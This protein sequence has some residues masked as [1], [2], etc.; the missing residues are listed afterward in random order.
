MATAGTAYQSLDESYLQGNVDELD[1]PE[2]SE[3]ILYDSQ[4]PISF[5]S[6]Y[7]TDDEIELECSQKV[8]ETTPAISEAQAKKLSTFARKRPSTSA[9]GG[10]TKKKAKPKLKAL[11]GKSR[12]VKLGVHFHHSDGE[13]VTPQTPQPDVQPPPFPKT[14]KAGK[15]TSSATGRTCTIDNNS[16]TCSADMIGRRGTTFMCPPAVRQTLNTQRG[17]ATE[18]VAKLFY[19]LG[20]DVYVDKPEVPWFYGYRSQSTQLEVGLWHVDNKSKARKSGTKNSIRLDFDALHQ[21]K[22]SFDDI[23]NALQICDTEEF[24][25]Y[26]LNLGLSR[27]N[28]DHYLFLTV[29]KNQ[30]VASLRQWYIESGQGSDVMPKDL[31]A[32]RQGLRLNSDQLKKFRTFMDKHVD[33]FLPTFKNHEFKCDEAEHKAPDCPFCTPPGILPLQKYVQDMLSGN[34]IS[35]KNSY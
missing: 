17:N 28:G 10:P 3:D 26:V 4:I 21:L 13:D 8:K 18:D 22:S 12:P 31:K 32:G 5:D 7:P 23:E 35:Y 20:L 34:Y 11:G 27:M 16:K 1:I 6:L 24:L 9:D 33:E 15:N 30:G 19:K 25:G 14:T 29:D 2:F